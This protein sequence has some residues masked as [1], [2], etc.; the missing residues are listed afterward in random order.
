MIPRW[1]LEEAC[2]RKRCSL[3]QSPMRMTRQTLIEDTI[4]FWQ[5]RTAHNLCGED[6]REIAANLV[7]FFKVLSEWEIADR[8]RQQGPAV[9]GASDV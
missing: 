4:A 8:G 3:W 5:P 1:G 9:G 7:G 2:D 6:A